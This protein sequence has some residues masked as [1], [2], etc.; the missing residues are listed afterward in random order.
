MDSYDKFANDIIA[1]TPLFNRFSAEIAT[2]DRFE[3]ALLVSDLDTE[4]LTDDRAVFK[5]AADDDYLYE[6]LDASMSFKK[7]LYM[8]SGNRYRIEVA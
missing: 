5:T 1:R 2:E 4:I 3:L 8:K 6:D 7:T